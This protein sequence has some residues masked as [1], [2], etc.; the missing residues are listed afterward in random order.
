VKACGALIVS[1]GLLLAA[2]CDAYVV[3]RGGAAAAG[4]LQRV[5]GESRCIKSRLLH[6]FPFEASQATAAQATTAADAT[7]TWCVC[8]P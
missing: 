5:M 6:Y 7:S 4:R 3:A 2:H 8:R 1:V